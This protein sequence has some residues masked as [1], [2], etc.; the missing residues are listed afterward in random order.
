MLPASAKRT[1]ELLSLMSRNPVTIDRQATLDDALARME[2]Y[3]FRHLPVVECNRVLGMLSDRDLRLATGLLRAEHRLRNRHGRKLPGP[4]RVLEVMRHPVHC[5]G[6]HATSLQAAQDMLRLG[7]G[8]IPVIK[9]GCLVGIVTE[10]DLLRAFVKQCRETHNEAPARSHMHAPLPTIDC[11]ASIEEALEALD[12]RIGH[13]CVLEDGALSGIVSER[14]LRVGLARASQRDLCAQSEGRRVLDP[15]RVR[16]VLTTRVITAS[17]E[18]PLS[19]S[20]ARMLDHKIG[21][22]PILDGERPL[23]ILTQRDLLLC[24]VAA[25]GERT[26]QP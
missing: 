12:L 16:E 15:V 9:D 14:D 24:F 10:T 20:A 17:P 1:Q 7:I 6:V 25:A 13:L 18:T 5:R 2:S 21:A 26:E 23:G 11:A 8:A 3:G 4:E 19:T 22:L